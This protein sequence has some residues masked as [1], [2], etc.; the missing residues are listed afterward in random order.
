[1]SKRTLI[2][3]GY[4]VTMDPDVGVLEAGDVLLSDDTIEAVGEHLDAPDAEVVDA[5]DRLVI[6]GMIDTHR[7]TWQTQMRAICS[8][9]SISGYMN[10]LRMAISPSYTPEDMHIGNLV[11]ALEAID[12]GVTTVLDFSHCNNSPEHAD[13]AVAGLLDSGIRAVFAYGFFDSNPP[14]KGFES[15]AARVADFHRLVREHSGQSR[16]RLGVSVNEL[17]FVPFSQTEAEIAAGR[18]AD[19]IIAFHTACFFGTPLSNGIKDLHRAGLLG[20]DQ[21]HIHCVALDDLEWQYLG[22]AGA[23]VSIAAETEMNMGMG[24]PQ[25]ANCRRHHIKPTLSCDIISLNSGSLVPQMRL[26]IAADRHAQNEPVNQAG[27]MP[28]SLGTSVMDVLR[29]VTVNGAEACGLGHVTGSLTAG[30][31]ADVVIVG[32]RGTFTGQPSVNPVG[33]LIFQSTPQDILDVFI[34]GRHVKKDGKLVGVDLPALFARSGASAAEVL[35]KVHKDFPVLPPSV[36]G[37]IFAER[38]KQAVGN[39]AAR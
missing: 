8:D 35:R 22:E 24:W 13:G 30:K 27:A 9:M 1:M 38:E 16:V 39:I 20:P 6:P 34:D 25:M 29:W 23:K 32:N 36:E 5:T 28:E 31:K 17:G 2:K 15:H 14:V 26:A 18:A 37:S 3:G 4:V 12:A 21:V 33:S 10:T 7:H 11:G 19:G